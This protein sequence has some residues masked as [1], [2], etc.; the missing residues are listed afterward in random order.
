MIM[1]AVNILQPTTNMEVDW[2]GL[3]L[4]SEQQNIGDTI[5]KFGY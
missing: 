5:G 1:F 4:C 2:S 3:I